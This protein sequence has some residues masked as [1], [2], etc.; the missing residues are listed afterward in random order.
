[1][2]DPKEP[3]SVYKGENATEAHLVMNLLLDEG[4]EA[5]VSEENEPLAGLSIAAPDVLVRREDEV[6]A[7]AIIERYDDQQ[8]QRAARPD[9]KCPTCGATVL[10]AL[11]ECDRCGA[12]LPGS[13]ADDDYLVDEEDQGE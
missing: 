1:L 5:F 2:S 9:W 13:D 12:A 3:V 10:G 11:D 8:L 4:I 7:R 6:R